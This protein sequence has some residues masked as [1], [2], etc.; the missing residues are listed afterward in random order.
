MLFP[1]ATMLGPMECIGFE[2]TF[3]ETADI[4]SGQ[5]QTFSHEDLSPAQAVTSLIGPVMW[6]KSIDVRVNSIQVEQQIHDFNLKSLYTINRYWEMGSCPH[7]FFLGQ[8]TILPEYYGELFAKQPGESHQEIIIIPSGIDTVLIVELEP[9]QTIIEEISINKSLYRTMVRL[10]QG[11]ALSIPVKSGDLI[12][13]KGH[14]ISKS[15][16]ATDPWFR[17]ALVHGFILEG[18]GLKSHS[19]QS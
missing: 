13:L 4:P 5:V 12:D 8:E 7:I 14:Y 9:E 18:A 10:N 16:A 19:I 3:Q 6:P 2:S 1:V 17:N 15:T 11:D